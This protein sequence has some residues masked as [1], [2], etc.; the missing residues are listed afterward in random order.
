MVG[1]M[2]EIKEGVGGGLRRGDMV[3]SDLRIL[4]N[5]L[6]KLTTVKQ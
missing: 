6:S 1:D 5:R 2:V 4:T 3:K